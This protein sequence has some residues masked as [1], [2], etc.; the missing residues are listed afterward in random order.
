MYLDLTKTILIVAGVVLIL[1]YGT[2]RGGQSARN[3][4]LGRI[5][6]GMVFAGI[7]LQLW[8]WW[9]LYA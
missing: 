4:K 6:A 8:I 2:S 1:W 3:L 9:S 5:G 7:A